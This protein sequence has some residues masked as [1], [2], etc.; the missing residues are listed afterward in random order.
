M[1]D[2]K[3]GFSGDDA[4]AKVVS[5][6]SEYPNKSGKVK[7]IIHGGGKAPGITVQG[8][9]ESSAAK[10]GEDVFIVTLTE[11]WNKGEFRHYRIYEVSPT[12]VK[13]VKEGGDVSPEAY[14]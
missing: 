1:R 9:F 6:K 13:F 8:E 11:Y 5:E 2:K 4:I 7:G 10:K 14:N 3:E 12:N